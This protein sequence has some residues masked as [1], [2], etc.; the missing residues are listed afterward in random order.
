[1]FASDVPGQPDPVAYWIA[2][3]G[4]PEAF[5]REVIVPRLNTWLALL[6]PASDTPLTPLEQVHAVLG[7]IKFKPQADGTLSASA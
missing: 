7:A 2:H 4:G 5:T 1:M 3:F 6:F